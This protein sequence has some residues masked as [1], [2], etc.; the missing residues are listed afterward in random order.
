MD[1]SIIILSYNTKDITRRCL[2][3]LKVAKVY[4]EKRLGNKIEVIILD[5]ASE[6]GSAQMI[7]EDFPWVKLIV[8][9]ENTGFSKG[10]NLAMKQ[11]K[12]PYI[13]LLNSDVYL[14]EESLYKTLAYFRVNLNCDL[15][16]ARLNYS[17][18][19]LQPSAGYL[20]T[21]LNSV[22]WIFG[23]SNIPVIERFTQPFH[24]TYRSFFARAHQVGWVSGAFLMLKR[25][26]FDKTHGFD[27]NIFMYMDEVEW[28]KRIKDLGFK[29]WYVPRVEVVHLHGASNKFDL[30]MQY[31]NELKGIKYYFKKHYPSQYLLVRPVLILG[32]ILRIIAF[33]LI[34]KTQ[35]ARAYMEGLSVI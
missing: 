26:V 19:K 35:R 21:P 34:G 22:P 20:L 9:K 6:D 11:S 15:S 2:E 10:N 7:K 1:L 25:S 24:P 31:I 8:S 27:E 32:V 4:C 33:S 14:E 17:T 23:I 28:C 30:K 5:N 29:V 18:G 13:L 12:N 16:G 3:K